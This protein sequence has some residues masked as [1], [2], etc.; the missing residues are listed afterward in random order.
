MNNNFDNEA[1]VNLLSRF[2]DRV[3]I[4]G[5]NEAQEFNMLLQTLARIQQGELAVIVQE[6]D[7]ENI[8]PINPLS[9]VPRAEG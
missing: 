6:Q 1:F 5:S 4:K 7:K 3:E 8:P 9:T 2:L